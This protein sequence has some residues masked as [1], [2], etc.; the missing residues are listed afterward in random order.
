MR[1]LLDLDGTLT[2]PLVGIT[3]SI[4]HAL[5]A[6]DVDVPPA[7]DLR[8]CIG[9]PLHESFKAL[10]DTTE[11]EP[12]FEALRIYRERFGTV[13]LFENK[14]YPDVEHCLETL[15]REGHCLSVATSKPTVFAE[16]IVEH[17]ELA[18]HFIAVDGSE[19]DGT[20]CDK[21]AL[22]SH[23]LVRD[24]LVPDEVIMI[25]DRKHDM[26]GAAANGV[27]GIGV[28]WGYG[29]EDELQEAGASRCVAHPSQL[30]AA[31]EQAAREGAR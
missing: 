29:A 27:P 30:P 20:R 19:L 2:D 28:L 7:S 10:L 24:N 1:L 6:L 26:I 17:F 14:I 25:G 23:I 13:G 4:Q 22:I 15:S 18:E 3:S 8:W 9:P 12:A 31:V 11:D 16:R 21:A 5:S